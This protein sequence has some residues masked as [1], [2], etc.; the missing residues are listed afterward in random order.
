MCMYLAAFIWTS[1][2]KY[3]SDARSSP[4]TAWCKDAGGRG[5]AAVVTTGSRIPG[6]TRGKVISALW[7]EDMFVFVDLCI[8]TGRT[9]GRMKD[10]SVFTQKYACPCC[11]LW[12]VP[13]VHVH[14]A[15]LWPMIWNTQTTC[16]RNACRYFVKSQLVDYSESKPIFVRWARG[17][18]YLIRKKNC[19]SYI[20]RLVGLQVLLAT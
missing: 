4:H 9:R 2:R 3:I 11:V 5:Q 8:V 6:T 19:T 20:L 1:Y 7:S 15:I 12:P 18:L 14:V 10:L 17:L 13:S 16:C